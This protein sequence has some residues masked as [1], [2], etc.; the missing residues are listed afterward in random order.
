VAGRGRFRDFA[1]RVL[2]AVAPIIPGP[3]RSRSHPT[4]TPTPPP[5]P[6]SEPERFKGGQKRRNPYREAWGN[7]G[8]GYSRAKEMFDSLAGIPDLGE[9][10]KLELWD[11]FLD[12]IIASGHTKRQ[13]PRNPF[14]RQSGTH[15]NDFDWDE[16]KILMK[17]RGSP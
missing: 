13:D 6:P 12:N 5:R 2:H 1:R 14:W 17:Q 11:S 7:L 10:D 8:A 15:P 9:A 16:F 3:G 4:P